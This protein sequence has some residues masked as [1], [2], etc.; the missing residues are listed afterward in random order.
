MPITSF[1]PLSTRVSKG[2]N[3]LADGRR[4]RVHDDSHKGMAPDWEVED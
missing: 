3:G 4:G 2:L 1:C